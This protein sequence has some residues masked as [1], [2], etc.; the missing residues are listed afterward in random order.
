MKELIKKRVPAKAIDA[1]M[2]AFDLGYNY[3]LGQAKK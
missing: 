2:R 3:V 1:N